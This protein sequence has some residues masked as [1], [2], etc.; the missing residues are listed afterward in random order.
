MDQEATNP[1]FV[2]MSDFDE[3]EGNGSGPGG[4]KGVN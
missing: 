2:E 1:E 4:V 3:D